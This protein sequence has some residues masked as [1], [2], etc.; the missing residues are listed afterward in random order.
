MP[1]FKQ[2]DIDRVGGDSISWALDDLRQKCEAIVSQLKTS[3]SWTDED[4]RVKIFH[5]LRN[6]I[7]DT[8]ALFAFHRSIFPSEN[9]WKAYFVAVPTPQDFENHYRELD[10]MI[11]FANFHAIFSLYEAHTRALVRTID[12]NACNSGLAAFDNIINWLFARLNPNDDFKQLKELLRL[13]RNTIHNNGV[14]RPENNQDK[15]IVFKNQTYSFK[16][17]QPIDFVDWKFVS[18]INDELINL[19]QFIETHSLVIAS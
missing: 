12:P 1:E 5:E 4:P 6:A 10:V 8:L 14:Y 7:Q 16:V 9:F 19:C 15:D 2:A 18:M 17:G 3:Y 11:R 13:V